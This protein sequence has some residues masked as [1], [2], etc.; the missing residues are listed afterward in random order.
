MLC[1]VVIVDRKL[2]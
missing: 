1:F 2:I